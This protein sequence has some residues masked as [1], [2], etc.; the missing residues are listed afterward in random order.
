M[1]AKV[2]SVS[3]KF[4]LRVSFFVCKWMGQILIL[5]LFYKLTLSLYTVALL[6]SLRS[7]YRELISPMDFQTWSPSIF[8]WILHSYGGEVKWINDV[9]ECATKVGMNI[10][11]RHCAGQPPLLEKYLPRS[12]LSFLL[13]LRKGNVT[14]NFGNIIFLCRLFWVKRFKRKNIVATLISHKI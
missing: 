12:L 1:Y 7:M 5:Y 14:T 2:W 9:C 11:W 10:L 8:V 13:L 4:K 3:T 6:Q